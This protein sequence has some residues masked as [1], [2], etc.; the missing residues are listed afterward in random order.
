MT[1][2]QVRIPKGW[3]VLRR[4][5]IVRNGDKWMTGLVR[6]GSMTPSGFWIPTGWPGDHV[7]H[8]IYIRRIAK[9]RKASASKKRGAKK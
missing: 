3:R 9:P 4:G 6:D 1:T 8:S 5:T 2:K 7:N